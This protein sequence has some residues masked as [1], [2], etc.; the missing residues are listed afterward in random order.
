MCKLPTVKSD[1]LYSAL[2][3]INSRGSD[4]FLHL[5][6]IFHW[7]NLVPYMRKAEMKVGTLRQDPVHI[8]LWVVGQIGS[9]VVIYILSHKKLE[10]WLQQLWWIFPAFHHLRNSDWTPAEA[11]ESVV[12]YFLSNHCKTF[13][14]QP[15][16]LDII[17]VTDF[18]F[19]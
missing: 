7:Q 18:E 10:R 14:L 4:S 19:I 6:T 17:S 11:T 2:K 8:I 3:P 1:T 5:H 15:G 9:S 12:N 13:K 16:T